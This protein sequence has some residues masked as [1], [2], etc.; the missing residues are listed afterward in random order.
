MSKKSST[1]KSNV[2][3]CG[4]SIK[5]I[6]KTPLNTV[7]IAYS[8]RPDFDKTC[9]KTATIKPMPAIFKSKVISIFLVYKNKIHKKSPPKTPSV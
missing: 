2:S 6:S 5:I 9:C 3:S 7:S 8:S 4:K 1:A